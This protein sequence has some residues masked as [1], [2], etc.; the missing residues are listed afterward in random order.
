VK[1]IN[2]MALSNEERKRK[3]EEEKLIRGKKV[4]TL[5][6]MVD[7]YDNNGKRRTSI[8]VNKEMIIDESQRFAFTQGNLQSWICANYP[9]GKSRSLSVTGIKKCNIEDY[10]RLRGL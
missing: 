4:I 8:A 7:I 3:A 1:N 2:I 6:G 5:K 10:Y 9:G